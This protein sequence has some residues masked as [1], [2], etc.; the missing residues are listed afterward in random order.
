MA[1]WRRYLLTWV[2]I[3]ASRSLSPAG[4]G[5]L[6]LMLHISGGGKT[7]GL[8]SSLSM[9]RLLISPRQTGSRSILFRWIA[10]TFSDVRLEIS[11]GISLILFL[12][13]SRISKVGS[14]RI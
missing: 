13:T 5:A 9:W 10:S 6:S 11:S 14:C 7:I 4:A 3:R 12:L 2:V 1:T 8:P